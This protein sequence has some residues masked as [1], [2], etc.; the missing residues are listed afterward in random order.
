MPI[1]TTRV[2]DIS[3]S[4]AF[5]Q[6]VSL[7]NDLLW[8]QF[9][10]HFDEMSTKY[11]G[12]QKERM[13][14]SRIRLEIREPK[15]RFGQKSQPWE[16]SFDIQ[17]IMSPQ[18]PVWGRM[19]TIGDGPRY[20]GAW[21][22]YRDVGSPEDMAK[23]LVAMAGG[24]MEYLAIDIPEDEVRPVRMQL[25]PQGPLTEP[26]YGVQSS[27]GVLESFETD[28]ERAQRLEQETE[29]APGLGR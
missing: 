12:E 15:Q 9:N 17:V 25:C 2:A 27:P 7:Y 21:A 3:I 8:A 11:P 29:A 23:T 19:E 5:R 4:E 16:A 26:G 1:H 14:R 18:G 28:A 6:Q 13:F 22:D 20:E 24:L 10:Q